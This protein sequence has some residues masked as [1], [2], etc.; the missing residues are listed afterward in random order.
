VQRE[1]ETGRH[2]AGAE[3]A[4]AIGRRMIMAPHRGGGQAQFVERPL[5]GVL[6][7]R[8]ELEAAELT[9]PFKQAHRE[10]YLLTEAERTT[11]VYSNRFAAHV[12][13]QH[14][15][16]ALAETRGWRYRLQGDFDSGGGGAELDL[17]QHAL[18]A[19]F[20]VDVPHDAGDLSETG[21]YVHVLSDQ[22]RFTGH[23][24]EAVPLERVPVRVFSE[25]MRDVDLFV[26]VTSIGNDPTWRDQGDRR[27]D[28]YW[29]SYAFGELGAQAEVRRELLEYL[30]PKLAIAEVAEVDGRYLRVR[31]KLRT[32]RIHLG[33]S[34][35]LMEPNDEYLCIVGGR[36]PDVR[37][38][39]YLPFEG[40][41]VLALILSKALLLARDDKIEDR[42][43]T[44]QIRA[45]R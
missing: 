27:Y 21:V 41:H 17:P 13:R 30:L 44:A 16:A 24:D 40:D 37:G 23:G 11:D 8:R 2:A 45:A 12:L 35:I 43:I 28:E 19:G 14:Q 9:Q 34:N 42:T 31:G 15:M 6:R 4:N 25:V 26:G 3:R 5:P 29:T 32:Y 18:Q 20:W 39:V 22:V 36:D 1:V 7:W 33:S 10:V 38:R